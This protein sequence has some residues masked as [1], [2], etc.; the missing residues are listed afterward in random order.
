[1]SA[2]LDKLVE[3]IRA[4]RSKKLPQANARLE[5]LQAAKNA[6]LTTRTRAAAVAANNPDLQAKL[7]VV[8]YDTTLQSLNDAIKAEVRAVKRLSHESINIGVAG[9]AR[10]GKSQILQML[11]GLTDKQIPTGDGGYCTGSRSEI[12]NAGK[13]LARVYFKESADLMQQIILPLCT[14]LGVSP[15]PGSVEAFVQTALPAQPK[16]IDKVNEWNNLDELQRDL[17]DNPELMEKLDAQ[18][19]EV[20]FNDLRQYVTKDDGDKWFQVVDRVYVETCFDSGLPQGMK[21][22][23]LPG[24]EDPTQGVLETM[25]KSI[26][27]DADIVFLMR[28]PDPMGDDWGKGDIK[29]NN[30]LQK[31]YANDGIEPKDWLLL[32][33]N[34]VR[35]HEKVDEDGK[36]KIIPDN[37]KNLDKMLNNV[38]YRF[39]GFHAVKCD[40]GSKDAVRAMV[41]DNIEI[42]VQ[43]TSRIDDLRIK[44]ADDSYEVAMSA[45]RSVADGFASAIGQLVAQSGGFDMDAHQDGFWADLRAPFK[46]PIEQQLEGMQEKIKNA[47]KLAFGASYAQIKKIYD[48]YENDPSKKFSDE[49]PVFS[50]DRLVELLK[51][52]HGTKEVIDRASRNQLSAVVQLLREELCN[53]CDELR[54]IYLRNVVQSVTKD[55]AA[56]QSLLRTASTEMTE[57]PED[58]FKALASRLEEGGGSVETIVSA[59]DNLLHFDVSYETQLLPYLFDAP[60]FSDKFDP[61]SPKS[62]LG[63]L[64]KYLN[65]EHPGDFAAQANVLFNA[66][67]T[68]T[69]N[70]IAPLAN[71]RSEG[72]CQEVS[73]G[74]MR[75]VKAN[76]RNFI[77]LFVWGEKTE[78]EW[79]RYTRDNAATLW[80]EDFEKASAQSQIGSELRDILAKLRRAAS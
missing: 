65:L 27:E 19:I 80:P 45:V 66:L 6:V 72:P 32:V 25:L 52:A 22:F 2:N 75:V 34:H 53:C 50:R 15:R 48:D 44:Q 55:N 58:V 61:Y 33:M 17:R 77:A 30:D 43:Q 23:D 28:K 31:I 16:D 79:K 74:I 40:C 78:S 21:V 39:P 26:K 70:W 38:H 36:R 63:E 20:D 5:K 13:N 59:L 7:N 46:A 29:I 76:Y 37:E 69:L 1:M 14:S 64:E 67:K 56:I 41:N 8:R 3:G 42:L 57:N 71:S 10:Q 62:D 9:K 12:R 24:L 35:E 18:P 11:T 49:F 54:R 73:V 68:Y 51:G 60:E 47:L 4:K